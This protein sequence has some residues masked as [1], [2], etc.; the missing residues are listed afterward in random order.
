[1]NNQLQNELRVLKIIVKGFSFTKE[2]L[3]RK[4]ASGEISQY[5]YDEVARHYFEEDEAIA[6]DAIENIV[7]H[8]KAN[9]CIENDEISNHTFEEVIRQYN[10]IVE[11]QDSKEFSNREYSTLYSACDVIQKRITGVDL[12][13]FD[14]F[15]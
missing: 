13:G 8:I 2:R 10:R 3:R 14:L 9:N 5:E 15:L 12:R 4:L 1:M 6:N 7:N 11:L